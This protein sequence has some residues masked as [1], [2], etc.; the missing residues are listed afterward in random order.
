MTTNMQFDPTAV[1]GIDPN[2]VE[3]SGVTYPTIQWHYGDVKLKKA[4]GMDYQGGWFIK[5]EAVDE[6]ALLA[7]GWEKTSWSHANGAE[8]E[9]F[10]RREIAVSIIALRKRWEVNSANQ[11]LA[12]AW[13]DYETAKAQGKASGRTHVLVVVKGL[14]DVGPMILTLKGM[15]AMAFE[16][17]RQDAGAL[18]AFT[19]TVI[20]A[21][22]KA[23]DTA[24]KQNGQRS[25]KRWPYRAFWLPVGAN[26]QADGQPLFTEVGKGKDVTRVVLPVALGLPAKAEQVQLN[27]FYVGNVLL[28]TVNELWQM[29]EESWTHAWDSL[30]PTIQTVETLNGHATEEDPTPTPDVMSALGL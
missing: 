18:S 19:A 4:G 20:T 27:S 15:S 3:N 10:Y 5:A 24:A 13:S 2:S 29:A 6:E 21:A 26:R 9:G 16:G 28:A 12:F 17:T 22:N 25:A 14:E 30:T 1:D 23:S 8:D 11:R 7:A